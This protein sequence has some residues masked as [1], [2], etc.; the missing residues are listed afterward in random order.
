MRLLATGERVILSHPNALNQAA[1]FALSAA[2]C[3]VRRT[4]TINSHFSYIDQRT[5]R[6]VLGWAVKEQSP[7]DVCVVF[8]GRYFG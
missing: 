1:P 3:V 2:T 8:S 4:G 6:E 7:A 5:A